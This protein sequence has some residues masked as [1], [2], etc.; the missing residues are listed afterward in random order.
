MSSRL[1][2]PK[3][4]KSDLSQ[5]DTQRAIK[6]TKDTFQ[7]KLAA[8]LNLD[9]VTAPVMVTKASG[10]NDDLNGVERKVHFTMKEVEGEAEVV[11]SL[12]KWKRQALYRYAYTPGEGIYTDMNAIRRDD[13]C[14]NLHSLFVDQWDWEKVI[15]REDRTVEYLQATVKK[16]VGA[17]YETNEILKAAYPVLH[18]EICPDVFFITTQ[19]LEDMYPDHTPKER[20]NAIVKEHKTVFLMQIGGALKSGFKHDG[21]A[22]D[23]DDWQLNGDILVWNEVLGCAFELSS[24]GIRVDETSLHEQLIKSDALQRE[25]FPYHKAILSGELP[26]SIGGGIG[27]S[28]LCMLLLGK[29]HI[30]EVQVSVWP[31]AMRETCAAHNIILL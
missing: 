15:T 26:L 31:E 28:R 4:Y 22:P 8:A 20:E 10:I 24:M 3:D 30:G 7:V 1:V 25:A 19:Q 27:Q 18:T 21:R 23:Y 14:D 29:A 16:I 6:L 2:F 5:R 17:L 12:A 13:D 11:Q 9:R